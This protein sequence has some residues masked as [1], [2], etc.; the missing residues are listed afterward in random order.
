MSHSRQR[1]ALPQTLHLQLAQRLRE[2]ILVQ[3][4]PPGTRLPSVRACA[5]EQ[6]VN[7]QTVVAAY[8]LLQAQGLVEARARQG[9]FVRGAAIATPRSDGAHEAKAPCSPRLPPPT[10]ATALLRAVLGHTAPVGEA[11]ETDGPAAVR[12]MPGCGSL[13]AQWLQAPPL[14]RALRRLLREC[15]G[16][17]TAQ[18]YAC[19][20]GDP[21]LRAQLA[22]LLAEREVPA[23]PSSLLLCNGS[24]QA[25][26][27]LARALLRPGDAVMVEQPGPPLAF[28]QLAR[29]GLCLLA[30]PRGAQGP[31][32]QRVQHWA[33]NLRPRLMLVSSRLHNP[34]G[35]DISTGC[36]HRLLELAREHDFLIAEDD[37]HAPLSDGGPPLLSAMDGLRRTLLFGGFSQLLAPGWRVGFIAAPGSLAE[38]LREAKLL[39]GLASPALTERALALLLERGA[40]PRQ[41]AALRERLARARRQAVHTARQY[42]CRFETPP[43][44]LFGWV[45]TGVDTERLALR[46][47]ERGY[48]IAPGR[49]FDPEARAS[50]RMRLNFAH[51]QDPDFWREYAL[52]LRACAA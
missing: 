3:C 27:L 36:A 25:L 29:Q 1:A 22:R 43:R 24:T 50:T 19:V 2:Q 8:D 13:P 52:A 7:P 37:V 34:T 35:G 49:L 18:A 15:D 30:V 44:G 47:H 11:G 5:K 46:L 42:G 39:A 28:A 48:L 6:G 40:V 51:A 9:F 20:E 38:R 41:A 32:L 17:R 33:R 21:R 26:D 16:A 23:P 45:D 31:D 10:E 4:I 12:A 14:A